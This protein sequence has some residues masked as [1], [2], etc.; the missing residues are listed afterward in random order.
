MAATKSVGVAV[1]T[2]RVSWRRA[3][4]VDF[5]SVQGAVAA[6]G[7]GNVL[8]GLAGAIPTTLHPSPVAAIETTG[9]AARGVGVATGLALIVLAGVPKLV[10]VIV[11][12]PDAVVAASIAV[13]V[14]VLFVIG[15]REVVSGTS[16]SPRNGLI[17]GLS[18]WIGIGVE[19]D[20][21]FPEFLDGLAGGL[22]SHGMTTGGSVAVLITL[23]TMPRVARFS[24]RL[25]VAELPRLN[26][27]IRG[28]ARRHGLEAS[29]GRMEGASEE[30]LLM[31]LE[32]RGGE[33]GERDGG[34]ETGRE[35]RVTASR[36]AGHAV[37]RF[38]A[39][40]A[41]EEE[42][43]LQDRL[44]ELG[45]EVRSG[46]EEQEISLRLLRHLA[47]SVRHQQFRDVDIVTLKVAAESRTGGGALICRWRLRDRSGALF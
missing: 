43:N 35:L 2:Q 39:A 4:A 31:L 22:L 6:E 10:A 36:E 26:E 46:S 32:S 33:T 8:A 5:R 27:F 42:L 13:F 34:G 30:T 21:I 20:L 15:M 25:D 16:T 7:G 38:S 12:I 17:A 23:L 37:L 47:S 29:V 14:S 28:F 1:A 24:A 3:R 45:D 9:V 40:A 44:V 18:V 41:G 11:A 19:F